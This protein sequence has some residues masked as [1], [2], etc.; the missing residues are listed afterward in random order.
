VTRLLDAEINRGKNRLRVDLTEWKGVPKL[1]IRDYYASDGDFLPGKRGI[2][3]NEQQFNV[4]LRA[5]ESNIESIKEHF[6]GEIVRPSSKPPVLKIDDIFFSKNEFYR[7]S[8]VD[9]ED[10]ITIN[11]NH[12]LGTRLKDLVEELPPKSRNQI[13]VLLTAILGSFEK[14]L[15]Q[16][17]SSA[18]ISAEDL[19][20]VQMHYWGK[21]LADYLR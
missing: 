13:A 20:E 21:F 2:Q 19:I 9:G 18:K 4:L 11:P 8:N 6:L 12:P 3:L 17:E 16:V 15:S 10:Q 7:C 1:D 5:L 14:S